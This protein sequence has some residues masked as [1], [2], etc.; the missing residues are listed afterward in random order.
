MPWKKCSVQADFILAAKYCSM[1]FS[2]Y[3]IISLKI[4]TQYFALMLPHYSLK[5]VQFSRFIIEAVDHHWYCIFPLFMMDNDFS[6][7]EA[8]RKKS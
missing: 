6:N 8:K 3:M 5:N 2:N 1:L 7:L 4:I